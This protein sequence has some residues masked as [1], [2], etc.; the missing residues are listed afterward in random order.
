[1]ETGE[2][3]DICRERLDSWRQRLVSEH[4]TPVMML[5]VGHDHKKGQIELIT[6]EEIDDYQLLVFLRY[7]V[8]E[9]EKRGGHL[10]KAS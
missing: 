1:M 9:I 6:L 8:N 3:D 7:A 4:S 10:G 2:I 5:G